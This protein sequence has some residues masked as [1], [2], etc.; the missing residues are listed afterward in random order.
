MRQALVI[1]AGL[2]GVA[3]ISTGLWMIYKPLPF[4]FVGSL[5]FYATGLTLQQM[6]A[7]KKAG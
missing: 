2:I 1:L 7:E 6:Q 3:L 5:M 4:L